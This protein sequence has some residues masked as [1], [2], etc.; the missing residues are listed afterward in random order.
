MIIEE[1]PAVKFHHFSKEGVV[2][3]TTSSGVIREIE[4]KRQNGTPERTAISWAM[5]KKESG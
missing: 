5:Q 2:Y 3:A 1:Y 4:I